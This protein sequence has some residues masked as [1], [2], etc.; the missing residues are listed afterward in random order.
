MKEWI[1]EQRFLREGWI[2]EY[3]TI[4][5][6]D[7]YVNKNSADS[8]K[9]H[10]L[11][12]EDKWYLIYRP[13]ATH[14]PKFGVLHPCGKGTPDP[15]EMIRIDSVVDGAE[16]LQCPF[17][18]EYPSE[19][20]KLAWHTRE[21]EN[22]SGIGNYGPSDKEFGEALAAELRKQRPK[23]MRKVEEALR[24]SWEKFVRVK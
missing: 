14:S 10:V 13:A 4:N 18:K 1:F 12:S 5:E 6:D 11:Y 16:T 15:R 7:K 22:Q 2:T 24:K 9:T 23:Q 3:G 19:N 17:C 20:F 8:L 21:D